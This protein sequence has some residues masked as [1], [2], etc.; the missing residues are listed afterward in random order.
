[1]SLLLEALKKAERAKEEAQRKAREQ[2]QALSLEAAAAAPPAADAKPVM[3]RAELP[4]IRQP[5]EILSDDIAPKEPET[6]PAA[7]LQTSPLLDKPAPAARPAAQRPKAEA[8]RQT[9]AQAA[10]RATGKKVFEAKFKEPNPR[11][12]FYIMVGCLGVFALGTGIYFWY[13]LRP[14]PS[15][16]NTNPA[17][18]GNEVAVVPVE[19]KP[20]ATAPAGP[21]SIP[22]LPG[23]AAAA[24][25]LAPAPAP[26]APTAALAAA[27]AAAA[28]APKPAP[29]P[30]APTFTPQPRQIEHPALAQT[31]LPPQV[32]PKVDSAYTAYLAGDLA[33]ARTDYQEALREDAGNRDA[34]LGVAAIDVRTGRF[35]S[36]E[37]TYL[38]L[39]QTDP[40][41]AHAQAGLIALR[42]S[43]LDPLA[44]ESR[45]K[46]LLAADP[47]ANVLHFT[48]GNQMAQQGRWAE[49]Q[50]EYFKAFAA[51]P[52]NAD[53]AYNLAISLDHLRQFKVALEYYRRAIALAEKRGASF[54][55]AAARTRV[56][57]LGN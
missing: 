51:D 46:T 12:P 21:P 40:N 1:M 20:G 8:S 55:V 42:S 47:G 39:L 37:G 11:L 2:G 45:V 48:L 13:Q 17:K 43:R 6:A 26:A 16:V 30:G 27:A 32:H 10:D 23:T 56:A 19:G 5:L 7:A 35:E 4:D 25:T 3:T 22:G 15:L 38:R 50:Q 41:D 24:P 36:A 49:A 18:T 34:L 31:R 52:D 53:F 54:D 57:Q 44:T 9:E 29:V 33:A 14:P 28:A